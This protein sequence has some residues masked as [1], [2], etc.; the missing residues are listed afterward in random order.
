MRGPLRFVHP[1]DDHEFGCV[2][3]NHTHE[4]RLVAIW[5]ERLRLAV[6]LLRCARLSAD[7][8]SLQSR[9]TPGSVG[10]ND[11]FEHLEDRVGGFFPDDAAS[12]LR[13]TRMP[14]SSRRSP[15][16]DDTRL[17]PE[18]AVRQ[19]GSGCRELDRCHVDTLAICD[20]RVVDGHPF[21]PVPQQ[22]RRLARKPTVGDAA[23]TEPAQRPIVGGGPEQVGDLHRSDVA[24]DAKNPGRGQLAVRVVVVDGLARNLERAVFA[25]DDVT[26][27]DGIL[28]EGRCDQKRLQR[29]A[30]IDCI[31][32]CP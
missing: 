25:V 26:E 8:D 16:G 13:P 3:G 4:P 19:R 24:R 28:F 11:S 29:R 18:S 20:G 10:R 21:L 5:R 17:H 30:R 12:G 7:P 22:S 1:H 15:R 27:L 9:E 14:V 23:K 31:F 32:K 6:V 2:C